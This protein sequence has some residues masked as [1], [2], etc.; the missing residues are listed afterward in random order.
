VGFG[1]WWGVDMR[2]PGCFRD[3][4]VLRGRPGFVVVVFDHGNSAQGVPAD[5]GGD[6][7]DPGADAGR[8][9]A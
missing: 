6:D 1:G 8:D 9:W 4:F 5:G 3:L 7:G 2:I